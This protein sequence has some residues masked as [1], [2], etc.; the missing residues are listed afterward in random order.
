MA[1]P[2]VDIYADDSPSAQNA[3]ATPTQKPLGERLIDA[4]VI[5]DAQLN[6]ALREKKRSGGFLGSVLVKLGFI[7]EDILTDSLA[8]E[9]QT[10]VVDVLNIVIDEAVLD[11]IPYEVARKNRVIPL[12]VENRLITVAM[13]DAFDVVAIDNIEKITGLQL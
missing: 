9:T 13:A 11:L 12:A 1:T 8:A 7:T 4:G 10:E 6:L 3:K 5:T 2:Q